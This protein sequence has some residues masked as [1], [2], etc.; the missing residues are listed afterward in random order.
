M[1]MT[2]DKQEKRQVPGYGVFKSGDKVEFDE[3]LYNTGLFK[4]D[5]KKEG[6]K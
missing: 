4:K 1:K 6:D 5:K 2:Y 3:N